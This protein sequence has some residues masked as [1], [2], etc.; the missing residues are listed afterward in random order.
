M[1]SK[2]ADPGGGEGKGSGSA[3]RR[4][5]WG[6]YLAVVEQKCGS[7]LYHSSDAGG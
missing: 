1:R 4:V 6:C 2:N 5:N 7:A 3:Q